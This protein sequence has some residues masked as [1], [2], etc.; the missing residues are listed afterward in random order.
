MS[1]G[2]PYHDDVDYCL[3]DW[4]AAL[5][6]DVGQG[7][8]P[9]MS[10]I[11]KVRKQRELEQAAEQAVKDKSN[12]YFGVDQKAQL[13]YPDQD[14]AYTCHAVLNVQRVNDTQAN[15][16]LMAASASQAGVV[17]CDMP[18]IWAEILQKRGLLAM[19]DATTGGN[20]E[21]SA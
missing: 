16:R 5:A 15:I 19:P 17:S 8:N 1:E 21:Q 4:E 6:E 9:E 20:K 7:V 2:L 14:Y 18:Y 10:L 12:I 11:V 13:I 3:K